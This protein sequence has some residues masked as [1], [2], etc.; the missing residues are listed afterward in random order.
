MG[1]VGKPTFELYGRAREVSQQQ[2]IDAIHVSI[3]HDTDYAAAFVVLEKRRNSAEG[4]EGL[5]DAGAS[6][7]ASSFEFPT[8]GALR[9]NAGTI[10]TTTQVQPQRSP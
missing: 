4:V 9:A 5:A 1:R 7:S 8:I 3:T 6:F 2:G 10:A